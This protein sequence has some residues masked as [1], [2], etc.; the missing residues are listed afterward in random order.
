MP[1]EKR[2]AGFS[3]S[4]YSDATE[5]DADDRLLLEKAR[6]ATHDA[7]APYSKFQVGAAALL[8][9]S[10]VMSGTNQENAS[11]PAGICAERVLLSAISAVYP[12]TSVLVIAIS[13]QSSSAPS[14]IPVF[15]CGIC[16]Q[17][18]LEQEAKQGQSIRLL[19][20]G[21]SGEVFIIEKAADLIPFGF[22]GKQLL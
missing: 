18:L 6:Q 2:A 8:S 17:S 10:E 12:G 11:Y 15:P 22:T 20:A 14:A 13:Y 19:L 16:R 4:A 3:F 21:S 9:N 5:L 7:Y 1:A